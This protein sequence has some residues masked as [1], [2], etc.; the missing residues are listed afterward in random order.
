MSKKALI[1]LSLLIADFT[2]AAGTKTIKRMPSSETVKT[3][4]C[5]TADFSPNVDIR[6]EFAKDK[7]L[8]KLIDFGNDV[9]Q[10]PTD[11]WS[12]EISM[13][14][15]KELMSKGNAALAFHDQK[16]AKGSTGG[17]LLA[18]KK[19]SGYVSL[20]EKSGNNVYAVKNCNVSN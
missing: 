15:A 17:K 18:L 1:V 16:A 5:A 8:V 20:P 10:A 4:I 13:E 11:G 6:I 9:D 19:G 2:F 12:T 7:A 14:E 3:M